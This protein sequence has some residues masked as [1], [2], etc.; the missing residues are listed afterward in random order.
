MDKNRIMTKAKVR[1]KRFANFVAWVSC[2]FI[3]DNCLL[4]ASSLA[5]TSLLNIVPFMIVIFSIFAAFPF[6]DN[7]ADQVQSFIF[8]NF[9]PSAGESIQSHV[10]LFSEHAK[11]LPVTAFV[12]FFITAL[13]LMYNIERHLNSIW[14]VPVSRRVSMSI[15]LYWAMLTLGP[16]LLGLSLVAS[17]Y[18]G[19]LAIFHDVVLVG[20]NKLF[21]ILPWIAAFLAFLFLYYTVPNCKVR[22]KHAVI[23]ALTA[24][25]LFECA[26]KGFGFYLLHFPTYEMLY[27]ALAVIP[28][29][30][31]WLYLSWLI[32]L[33][34]AQVVNGLTLAQAGRSKFKQRKLVIAYDI[35]GYLSDAQGTGE[36]VTLA[37]IMDREKEGSLRTIRAVLQQLVDLKWITRV[38]G[39]QF[40]LASDLHQKTFYDLYIST[41][42]QLPENLPPSGGFRHK[43]L[44]KLVKSCRDQHQKA[45]A[46]P[47]INLLAPA[48]RSRSKRQSP[49]RQG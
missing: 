41:T 44:A 5:I 7:V 26:K 29:F 48:P 32:F 19:S 47:V 23:G 17:T 46:V 15:L 31:I 43:N 3:A 22:F 4:R 2:E 35:L 37:E 1:L 40:L 6:F 45:L 21:F 39:D 30:I 28:I 20:A 34:S 12:S 18:L 33:F 42:W 9:V 27:G 8:S 13:L 10:Q 25:V 49:A 36:T 14:K 38:S 16:L 11:K 24:T